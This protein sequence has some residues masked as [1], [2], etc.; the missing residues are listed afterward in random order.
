QGRG[1]EGRDPRVRRRQRSAREAAERGGGGRGAERHAPRAPGAARRERALLPAPRRARGPAAR[2]ERGPA[3]GA[4]RARPARPHVCAV[5]RLSTSVFFCKQK[6]AYEIV[7]DERYTRGDIDFTA[8]LGHIK[9]SPAEALVEWSR[10]SEG[11]LIA[12]QYAQTGLSLP[13]FGSDGFASPKYIELGGPAVN[14][15][16]Y[17]SHFSIA[18]S[19]GIPAAKSL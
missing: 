6:T 1:D 9:A 7:A 18:T 3:S 17:T 13:R 4:R 2:P 15:G 16:Y 5:V 8:Q 12:K 14:G 10:Y 11:A 19:A